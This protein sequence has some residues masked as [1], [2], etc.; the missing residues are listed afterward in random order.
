MRILR[1][2]VLFV[3]LG[4]AAAALPAH[5]PALAGVV[6]DDRNG[7]GARDGGEPGVAGARLS[8]QARTVESGPD[9]S[10]TIPDGGGFGIVSINPPA[11]YA[12]SGAFFKRTGGDPLDF[13]LV[14]AAAPRAFTFIH[15]SD[16]HVSPQT[17]ERLRRLRDIARAQRPAFVLLT[18][19]L[20]RDA[21]RVGEAE[22]RSYYDLYVREIA[23]LS[24]PVYSVPGNHE[25]FGIERDTS[26]VSADHPLYGKR[27]YRALVGPNYYSFD[28][29]GI[30]FVG[31][32]TADIWDQW[33]Y[34][35]V[36]AAQLTWLAGD[37]A[38]VPETTP[39]VTFN[40]IPFVTAVDVMNGYTESPPA[41]TLID[42]DGRKQYRHVVSNR[43][44]VFALLKGHPFPLALGGHMHT[45]EVL[46][47]EAEGLDT[48]FEQAAAVV[49]A[50]EVGPLR[51]RSG[52][53]VY[54]VRDGRIGEGRFIPLDRDK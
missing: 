46:R 6:F 47:Y 15:A 9:G 5:P 4:S 12:V 18:G 30:H 39:V 22:A 7:N 52:V 31:L 53:T 24:L 36:D 13:A 11:G 20:V 10:W 33:Y 2:S 38:H 43:G 16:C 35:H 1:S 28:F 54:D 49:G 27:M 8:D 42:V 25:N 14:R 50:N 45:R 23:Q 32:D 3:V 40:H 51:M 34:G 29:G 37:L 41:P 44:D 48:R 19:D 21:L 17:V 26:H